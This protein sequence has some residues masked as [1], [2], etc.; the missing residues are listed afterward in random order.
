[1]I[2]S[3]VRGAEKD[4]KDSPPF[5]G[6]CIQMTRLEKAKKYVSDARDTL[7]LTQWTIQVL[8]YPSADDALA[9]IEPHHHLWL[10]KLRLSAD[11]WK[12]PAD[13]QRKVIAHEML[14]LHYAGVERLIDS[15]EDA[16]GVAAFDVLAKVWE[17]EIERAADALSGPVG[18]L[19]PLP[20]F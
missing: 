15:A 4:S 14:H 13:E 6:E 12:E 18:R 11:F 19:L 10:A 20:K 7:G 2:Q 5:K 8:D 16:L 17:I 9:D 1:M 3:R